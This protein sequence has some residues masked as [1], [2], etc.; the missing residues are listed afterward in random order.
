MSETKKGE[1][2]RPFVKYANFYNRKLNCFESRG[3]PKLAKGYFCQ[4]SL[5]REWKLPNWLFN[6][7]LQFH[8]YG[9]FFSL[10]KKLGDLVPIFMLVRAKL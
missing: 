8:L 5:E 2:S 10:A 9:D 1:S 7:H 6:V 4:V 3:E